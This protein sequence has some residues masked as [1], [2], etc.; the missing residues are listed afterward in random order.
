MRRIH[1]PFLIAAVLCLLLAMNAFGQATAS[2]TLEGRITDKTQASIAGAEVKIS[3]KEN[4]LVRTTTSTN[5]GTYRF[6]L[7]PSGVYEVRISNKGF[8]TAA[9]QGVELAV[10]RTTSVDASLTISSQAEVVTV[11]ASGAALV[12][13]QKTDVSRAITPTE[14]LELPL[15]GRD[16]SNLAI[17]APGV[18]QVNSFDPTKNRIG[19]FATNGSTG[20]NVNVTVN[21]VDNKDGTVGGPVMQLPLEAVL[22]FNISTQ[23]FSAVNGRSE[24][25]AVNVITKSGTNAYHGA[26]YFFGRDQALNTINALETTK[27]A[28]S[29][30]QFGGA[31]GGP[32][33]KD[34][35]FLF[36]TLERTREQTEISITPQAFAELNLVAF[37][38]AKPAASV[39][40]P[41][42]D[43]RYNGR[44]DHRFN[45]KHALNFSYSNQNNTGANDQVTATTDLSSGN[46]TINSLILANATLNSVLSP[47]IVNA[48]TVGY[49]YW[50]NLIDTKEQGFWPVFPGGIAFGKNPN[51]P[52]ESY[53]AKWQFKDDLAITRGKHTFKTGFDFLYEPKLGGFFVS[54]GSVTPTF[55]DLP[56]VILGNKTK[57]PLGFATPG[58][59]QSITGSTGNPYFNLSGKMFGIYLNDDWK[60]TRNLTLSL[61][62]RYDRDFNLLGQD[63]LGNSRT[64]LA[65][66]AIN[67]PYAAALPEDTKK[68]FSP[69]VG[70]AWDMRGNGHHVIR[71]G[72]GIYYGQP[73][74]NI[75]LF[76]LQQANPTLFAQTLSLTSTGPGD[77]KA[78]IVPTTGRPLSEFRFG[79]DPLPS[80]PAAGTQLPAN[81]TGRL[82]DPN[83]KNPYVQQWNLGYTWAFSNTQAI[84][85]D[86]VHSL[87]LREG[88]QVNI[89]PINPVTGVRVYAAAFAAA[90]VTPLGAIRMDS[91]IGRSRYDGLNVS[92]RRRMSRHFSL[93][94]AYTLSKAVGYQ[95]VVGAFGGLATN[96]FQIFSPQDYGA[97]PNDERNRVVVSG[98]VDLPWGIKFAPVMQAASAR[99]YQ[100]T[101]G[102]TDVFGYGA[103]TG[104]THAITLNSDPSNLLAT[105]DFT[106]AQLQACIA[107][108]TCTQ[109]GGF[110]MRGQAF[111]QFDARFSKTLKFGE[112]MK[113]DLIFQAF[114]LTDRAN[115][116]NRFVG[117][118]KSTTFGMPNGFITPAG[119]I[120][121]RSFSGEFGARFSF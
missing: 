15:N 12:D 27:G 45:E 72:Y 10:G 31:I 20:R 120:V 7:L 52:Q 97:G 102:I 29:R 93:N 34:K 112:K 110:N 83:Y 115:F 36:F 70:F 119:T 44:L 9:F 105:K 32:V 24:G 107:G 50:H 108:G 6:D 113:L 8:A 21:G 64:Y 96:P 121:P 77:T 85:V 68:A 26:L 90:G 48:V 28:F 106:A 62:I 19:L 116:G 2:A 92:Y 100:A 71:G 55:I 30:Q 42:F 76:A 114:D 4:G 104:A 75:P 35:T 3:N 5:E 60:V 99:P 81:S 109:T 65:L 25:S 11:E 98:V 39:P 73:F 23:R 18:Q 54:N 84:E 58:A 41:Y 86:Y 111:F 91:S 33:K 1:F 40:T 14:I 22:E 66:K 56:S 53:Q 37:L 103:N 61:G 59:I 78:T 118:I 95:G 94:T 46:T 117:N 43:W 47:T 49:Q 63:Q 101:Q 69:R 80:I 88:K 87:A 17:L 51:V 79:V 74:I 57:Y 13:T 67:S 82:I 89:N 16:F 38:G